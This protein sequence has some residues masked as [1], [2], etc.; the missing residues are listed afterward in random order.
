MIFA[1]EEPIA[2]PEEFIFIREKD[3]FSLD[4]KFLTQGEDTVHLV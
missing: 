1:I 3:L 4:F 2:T